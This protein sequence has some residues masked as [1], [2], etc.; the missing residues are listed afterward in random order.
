[1]RVNVRILDVISVNLV[2]YYVGVRQNNNVRR[3]CHTPVL[4][5]PLPLV[6]ASVADLVRVRWG[7][8]CTHVLRESIVVT[9]G[10]VTT[11]RHRQDLA[12][13]H[14]PDGTPTGMGDVV[15]LHQHHGGIV[16]PLLDASLQRS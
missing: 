7:G 4:V 1:M 14:D 6:S 3:Y 16:R 5:L 11:E 15:Q 8:H 2:I 9:E 13:V 12:V 10:G